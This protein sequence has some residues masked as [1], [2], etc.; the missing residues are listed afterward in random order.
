[1]TDAYTSEP[2]YG[3]YK[4]EGVVGWTQVK[5]DP[6]FD[7]D[8]T[9]P[10]L[11]VVA[12]DTN[13]PVWVDGAFTTAV[14]A[15][16][17][18]TEIDLSIDPAPIDSGSGFL[19]YDL[20][21][22]DTDAL[23]LSGVS[24]TQTVSNLTPDT[25]Y[26]WYL[27]S[28]DV[29]LNSSRS[30]TYTHKTDANV[31]AGTVNLDST[32]FEQI[33][34]STPLA[35]GLTRSDGNTGDIA[36]TVSTI[37]RTTAGDGVAYDE[38]TNETVN[39]TGGGATTA[40]V[41]VT[42][43][44]QS[45]ASSNDM[46]EIQIDHGSE[47]TGAVT[48][49]IGTTNSALCK[50]L[51]SGS[52][53]AGYQQESSGDL[54]VV[55]ETEAANGTLVNSIRSGG[56]Y[57]TSDAW[58][59]NGPD[60]RLSP[61]GGSGQQIKPNNGLAFGDTTTIDARAPHA[62]YPINF[63]Q[64]G[65]HTIYTRMK[66]Y[67]STQ[68]RLHYALEREL[69]SIGGNGTGASEGGNSQ[70]ITLAA[71]HGMLVGDEVFFVDITGTAVDAYAYDASASTSFAIT[72]VPNTDEIE[73]A[74]TSLGAVPDASTAICFGEDRSIGVYSVPQ[75]PGG[76]R[77]TSVNSSSTAR[78]IYIGAAGAYN[79]RLYEQDYQAQP[80]K[81]VIAPTSVGY[82]P[83]V[84]GGATPEPTRDDEYGP[85]QSAYS[86]GTIADNPDN[87]TSPS[88]P[89]PAND[90][91]EI[92]LYPADNATNV[93]AIGLFIQ[94]EF[95]LTGIEASIFTVAVNGEN[96]S[97]TVFANVGTVSFA[98]TG[99]YP[100]SAAVVVTLEGTGRD[101]SNEL[102]S[103][104]YSGTDWNFTIIDTVAAGTLFSQDFSRFSQATVPRAYTNTD[105]ETDFNINTIGY[106]DAWIT[107]PNKDRTYIAEDPAPNPTR[108][109]VLRITQPGGNVS[110]G[111]SVNVACDF[112]SGAAYDDSGPQEIYFSYDLFLAEDH[113]FTKI[114]KH[115]GLF[116]GTRL[117]A[118]HASEVPVPEGELAF[119]L[120]P[121]IYSNIAWW[122]PPYE[123][124]MSTYI[125]DALIVQKDDFWDTV[126][127][128]TNLYPNRDLANNNPYTPARGR[129]IRIE[130]YILMNTAGVSDGEIK[131]W[132]T[133]PTRWTG[134]KL[135][136][137]DTAR[138]FKETGKQ[139]SVDRFWLS[140][141]YGGNASDPDNQ[142]D[143]TQY[144]YFDN[145]I[146]STDPITH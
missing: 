12:L 17:P 114:Q 72:G 79:L 123:A 31:T 108:G 82:D 142:L 30:N 86:A 92:E 24:D 127:E 26:P 129:W 91:A 40:T 87:P 103:F 101:T 14:G 42:L 4:D 85:D 112:G 104:S 8:E 98:A 93:P 121:S 11:D 118:S 133:D 89:L 68:D 69:V 10:G 58:L 49:S 145:F 2:M 22:A 140:T 47:D 19:R 38:I 39:F 20:H 32:Y 59:V 61:S 90:I 18:L 109:K 16:D 23:V 6:A 28:Y 128:T 120:T 52:G 143:V 83:A 35:I 81:I 53:V 37:N 131:V 113:V 73:I 25:S 41:N 78:E 116:T 95:A 57:A 3:W 46:F 138:R 50:I 136:L 110:I 74:D 124:A 130:Q 144:H 15:G 51:S 122:M 119:S 34:S 97:G 139:M 45:S 33:E 71:D 62:R 36:V 44:D 132:V 67:Q 141:Y 94:A 9:I 76:W 100:N 64:T 105:F 107:G 135:V 96:V 7:D 54:K 13:A 1:M 29:S 134:A 63:T 77:W 125:Y 137:E 43:I 80:D 126:D 48:C 27:L 60:S 117:E 99:A 84:V 56:G 65:D 55:I 111:Q 66:R 5:P 75:D 88:E 106:G 102:R 146:V 70:L 21:N 115:P